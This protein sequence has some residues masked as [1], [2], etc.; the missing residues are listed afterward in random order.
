M[1]IFITG[2]CGFIGSHL[3]EFHLNQ[4][5][6]VHII[7][8]L[9]T[10]T[11]DNISSFNKKPE[12]KFFQADILTWPG[13]VKAIEWSDRIYHFAAIVGMFKAISEPL[14]IVSTN[15]I[16]CNHLFHEIAKTKSRPLVILPSSSSVYGDNPSHLLKETDNLRV[17]SL[18]HPLATYAISKLSDE[19]IAL[20]Y[21]QSAKIPVIIARLFNTIGPR[22]TGRYGMVVPRFVHQALHHEPFTIYGD[23]TQTRSFCDVRDIVSALNLLAKSPKA[24]GEIINVGNDIEIS[25]NELADLISKCIGY[26]VPVHFIPYKEAYGVEFTDITQRRPDLKKLLQLTSF[27]HQWTLKRTINDLLSHG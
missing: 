27:K 10:G 7:D 3:A 16:G 13:L 2:G 20:A 6:K 4:G 25:I 9:S 26:S 12:F 22:Q 18:P 1:N 24:V 14:S 5:D 8:N 11:L 19:S 17:K 15:I 23:G 21:Y